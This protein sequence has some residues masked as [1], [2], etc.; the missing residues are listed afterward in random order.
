[1]ATENISFTDAL[2]QYAVCIVNT[3]DLCYLIT[4]I[5]GLD[6]VNEEDDDSKNITGDTAI[7]IHCFI[8]KVCKFCV[9]CGVSKGTDV[10]KNNTQ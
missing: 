10:F 5:H 6:R 9:A 3:D 7:K 4:Y 8:E 2:K 1:M